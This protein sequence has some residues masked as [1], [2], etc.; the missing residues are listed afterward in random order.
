MKEIRLT[1]GKVAKVD[2][3]TFHLFDSITWAVCFTGTITKRPY[4][5]HYQGLVGNKQRYIKLHDMAWLA[6][7]GKL[8][9]KGMM[10]D[11]IDGDTLNNQVSN[12]R[13][14]THKENSWN[15]KVHRNSTTG[16]AGVS[17][18]RATGRYKAEI[19]SEGEHYILGTFST[20]SEAVKARAK[21]AYELW[22]EYARQV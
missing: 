16:Y 6:M 13:L 15:R 22:G 5:M 12:L 3:K 8:P 10:L 2:D 17:V 4:V 19:R 14:V 7:T 21:K 20:L 9:P 1:Q 18:V 11:H